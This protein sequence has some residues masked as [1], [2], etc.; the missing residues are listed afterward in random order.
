MKDL[1]SSGSALYQQARPSYPQDVVQEILNHVPER[2]FA[3]DCGAGSGQFTQLLSPY[4]DHIVATDLSEQQLQLAPYFDN[5]S[6][7]VQSAEHTSFAAQSFDL[8]SVAQAIHWFDF[9]GFYKEVQ[10]TLKPQGI[11]AVIG[12]GLIQVE[13]KTIHSMIQDLYFKKLKGYWDAERRYIDEEYQTIP[14]PFEEITVTNFKM[15]Y[16][17]S[18]AQLLKYLST[19]SA[20]KHY[21]EKNQDHPLLELAEQLSSEDQDLKIEFPV[22]LRLGRLKT[23]KKKCFMKK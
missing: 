4:F 21:C 19:W 14:F 17:W 5:V 10:R 18:S 15:Q 3:W 13:N 20:I 1:F 7:Q 22:F 11:L 23:V 8:I 6:Y 16:Q 9:D 12:Y 2:S